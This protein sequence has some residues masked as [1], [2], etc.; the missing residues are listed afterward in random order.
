MIIG[1]R[2]IGARR[3]RKKTM[4]LK[5]TKKK[6]KER[7]NRTRLNDL[8]YVDYNV[9]VEKV[10]KWCD[11]HGT[12]RDKDFFSFGLHFALSMACSN[13]IKHGVEI[14]DFEAETLEDS[15]RVIDKYNIV[16]VFM[17]MDNIDYMFMEEYSIWNNQI[18]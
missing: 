11:E 9:C 15:M 1:I 18:N 6:T 14:D 12:E 3:K 10:K 2:L 8:A 17:D 5:K 13:Y 16:D 4:T 7:K